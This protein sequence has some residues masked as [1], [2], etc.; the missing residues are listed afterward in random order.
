MPDGPELAPAK[1]LIADFYGKIRVLPPEK[2]PF[3]QLFPIEEANAA[4]G[5]SG[6][7]AGV[8]VAVKD[9]ISVAGGR[10]RAGTT[11]FDQLSHEDAAVVAMLRAQGA[12]IVGTTRTHEL[13][14]GPT[15]LNPHDGD[16]GLRNP[17]DDSRIGGGSSI[18]SAVAVA[19]GLTRIGLGTDTGGSVRAPAAL[20]GIFGFKPSLGLIPTQGVFPLSSTMDHVGILGRDLEDIRGGARALLPR[21]TQVSRSPARIKRLAVLESDV[22]DLAP[23]VEDCFDG[24][25]RAWEADGLV[26]ERVPFATHEHIM[27]VTG[28]IL[29]YEAGRRHAVLLE[30]HGHDISPL[31]RS[32]LEHGRSIPV[33]RYAAALA[34]RS[35]LISRLGLIFDRSDLI[36]GPTV[37][38][39]PPLVSEVE[40]VRVV[41]MVVRNTRLGNVTGVPAA[42]VPAWNGQRGIGIQYMAPH[43]QDWRLLDALH[44]LTA[45][46]MGG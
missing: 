3:V 9:V 8:P 12:L 1:R 14:L 21:T 36:V 25:V 29:F 30:E 31:V 34:E 11:F 6:E 19:T 10:M 18:G 43:G 23:A 44:E 40:D 46:G 20:C 33:E 39:L 42:S 45:P 16:G 41:S 26:V 28:T 37:P 22:A 5:G 38:I 17:W 7:L 27:E 2:N 24:Q 13:A 15:G 35:V 4:V 32:R